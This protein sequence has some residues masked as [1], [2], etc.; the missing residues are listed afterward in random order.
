[1]L[2]RITNKEAMEMAELENIGEDVRRGR[3]QFIGHIMTKGYHNNCRAVMTWAP[4]RNRR[5]GRPRTTW[6]R[7]A[8][9][10]RE[11]AG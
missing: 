2:D 8:E 11:R 4:E 5:Q 1:M 3:W 9:K 7:T 6:R 10:K